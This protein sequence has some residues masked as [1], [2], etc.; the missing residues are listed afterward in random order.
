[1]GRTVRSRNF[2][3]APYVKPVEKVELS[4]KNLKWRIFLV[5][6][7]IMIAAGS[8]AYGINAFLFRIAGWQ[9]INANSRNDA[10][11]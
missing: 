2:D 7:L 5:V 4:E 1:M 8:F 3:R 9:E 6:L 10:A 11:N